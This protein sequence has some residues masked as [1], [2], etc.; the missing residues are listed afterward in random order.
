MS[1]LELKYVRNK[2][3]IWKRRRGKSL[4]PVVW[5]KPFLQVSKSV[6]ALACYDR[7][8]IDALS[9]REIRFLIVWRWEY[10]WTL[11]VEREYKWN[12][13]SGPAASVLARTRGGSTIVRGLCASCIIDSDACHYHARW[14]HQLEHC[15]WQI[16]DPIIRII[17]ESRTSR[18]RCLRYFVNL[19]L[20]FMIALSIGIIPKVG[21]NICKH[22]WLFVIELI[23]WQMTLQLFCYLYDFNRVLLKWQ[24]RLDFQWNRTDGFLHDAIKKFIKSRNPVQVSTVT[25]PP[26]DIL[27]QH[28]PIRL[29]WIFHLQKTCFLSRIFHHSLHVLYSDLTR[30]SMH[31][32]KTHI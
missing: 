22:Y 23:S 30:H 5:R 19:L 15:T 32:T 3:L 9:S 28:R 8:R 10:V 24:F 25:F 26:A 27:G 7:R 4:G 12:T 11:A 31:T 6:I 21:D 1:L 18:T 16:L 29:I 2:W 20:I 13:R 14:Y 17:T